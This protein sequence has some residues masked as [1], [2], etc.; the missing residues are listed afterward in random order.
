MPART[1]RKTARKSNRRTPILWVVVL[2]LGLFLLWVYRSDRLGAILPVS[3]PQT[4]TGATTSA[5]RTRP[6]DNR[7]L[8][9]G[10]PSGAAHDPNQPKN[11][12]IERPQY[13]LSYN[14]DRGIANWVSWQ[15]TEKD[16][17]DAERNDN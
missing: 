6:S 15:L 8:Q 16:F 5:P 17:G 12:L 13:V 4:N 2:V 3:P 11:Y 14:R 7:N 9:L 1:K 10:N